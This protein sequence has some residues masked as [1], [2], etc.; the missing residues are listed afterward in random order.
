MLDTLQYVQLPDGTWAAVER[1]ITWGESVVILLL[2]ALVFLELYRL[3][4]QK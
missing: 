2:A 1:S 4:R 3:W